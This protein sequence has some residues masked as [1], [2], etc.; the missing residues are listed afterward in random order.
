MRYR[1]LT[2][3]GS[4]LVLPVGLA[5]LVKVAANTLSEGRTAI[6]LLLAFPCFELLVT[7][8]V[9]WTNPVVLHVNERTVVGRSLLGRKWIWQRSSLF[10]SGVRDLVDHLVGTFGVR[11]SEGKQAFRVWSRLMRGGMRL[12][13][14]L[15]GSMSTRTVQR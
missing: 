6:A 3:V 4:T 15:R 14:D 8:W 5:C 12:E 11:D 2:L 7:L 1:L 10:D 13:E 9:W